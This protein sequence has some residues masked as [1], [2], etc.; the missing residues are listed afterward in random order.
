MARALPGFDDEGWV[1][2]R[3]G[4]TGS[5]YKPR[6]V[7]ALRPGTAQSSCAARYCPR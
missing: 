5:G 4:G 6:R 7:P 2:T 3:G 1:R